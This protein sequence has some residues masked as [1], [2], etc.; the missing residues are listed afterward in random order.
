MGTQNVPGGLMSDTNVSEM[1]KSVCSPDSN[2]LPTDQRSEIFSHKQ[3][4]CFVIY[5]K[6]M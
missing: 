6:S 1:Q 2:L 4:E 3:N 5:G